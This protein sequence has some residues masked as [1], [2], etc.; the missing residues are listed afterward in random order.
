MFLQNVILS[1]YIIFFE[2]YKKN[3][4]VCTSN[5][6]D[7]FD[8]KT[9][10]YEVQKNIST[11]CG[12][13]LQII[14]DGKGIMYLNTVNAGLVK[15]D[16]NSWQGINSKKAFNGDY[17]FKNWEIRDLFINAKSKK[18]NCIEKGYGLFQLEG[19]IWKHDTTNMKNL[20]LFKGN[21]VQ[22]STTLYIP[23]ER[24]IIKFEGKKASY[25]IVEKS[26]LSNEIS[27]IFV[28]SKEKVWIASKLEYACSGID[29]I[30]K[31]SWIKHNDLTISSKKRF[32]AIGSIS[33]DFKGSIWVGNGSEHGISK[34]NGIS[35]TENT[36]DVSDRIYCVFHD[37]KNNVWVGNS[38]GLSKYDGQKWTYI[39]P[40]KSN[41]PVSD[42]IIKA[43]LSINSITE[44]TK[45][46]IW[47]GTRVGG[48]IKYNTKDVKTMYANNSN[49]PNNEIGGVYKNV[50]GGIY[51]W[52]KSE[53]YT[54]D[55]T[56]WNSIPMPK[57]YA[58]MITQDKYNNLFLLTQIGTIYQLIN[59][60]WHLASAEGLM[61]YF[62]SQSVSCFTV[63]KS[64]FWIGT[65]NYGVLKIK[66]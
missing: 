22:D 30:T 38:S 11:D 41:E 14:K 16:G 59:N 12:N 55:D 45:G 29:C 49:I 42:D 18:P 39:K 28:D 25:I 15:Y 1:K 17:T 57:G 6:L 31:D 23:S 53:L 33:E 19:S 5:G 9:W 51:V 13:V 66:R 58:T 47:L 60:E 21:L 27:A 8:G 54:Y 7:K 35:W 32:M 48:L 62:D 64:N 65:N 34:F 37:S 20:G 4:W 52:I 50:N 46:N 56:S 3:I 10:E 40:T 24:G 2:D 61:N 26:L 36:N 63:D 44:D 43:W